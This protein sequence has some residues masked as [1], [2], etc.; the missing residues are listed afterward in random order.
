MDKRFCQR[1][2]YGMTKNQQFKKQ[3]HRGAFSVLRACKEESVFKGKKVAASLTLALV[4]LLGLGSLGSQSALAVSSPK[5]AADSKGPQTEPPL[6]VKSLSYSNFE[7]ED[8]TKPFETEEQVIDRMET[9][10]ARFISEHYRVDR[11]DASEIV[12]Q[13]FISGK[14]HDVDPLLI[15]AVIATESSFDPKAGSSVGAKGLMQVHAKVHAKRF[16]EF[17]GLKAVHEVEA[18]IEVGTQILK[19]YLNKTGSL[20]GALKYYVGA[21]KH[22]HD[23]GYSR[24]VLSMRNHLRLAASGQ[25]E[26]AK[27]QARA[28]SKFP[29]NYR[30][31]PV[32]ATYGANLARAITEGYK[33]TQTSGSAD[34]NGSA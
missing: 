22:S 23:G 25:V 9:N 16:K 19:E 18:G 5:V 7:R 26:A 31:G 24:K 15:L 12:E 13:A 3:T 8:L 6:K 20:K 1:H 4:V 33:T 10:A 28:P 11:E 14:N 29:E 2:H 34:G 32:F 30:D 27:I 21:A 17:G